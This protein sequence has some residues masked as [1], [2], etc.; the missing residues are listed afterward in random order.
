MDRR[1]TYHGITVD[2]TLFQIPEMVIRIDTQI[3]VHTK[4]DTDED[5]IQPN[6]LHFNS[7]EY[8]DW[9]WTFWRNIY[10]HF[11]GPQQTWSMSD[12]VECILMLEHVIIVCVANAVCRLTLSWWYTTPF[13][14]ANLYRFWSINFFNQLLAISVPGRQS[15][16]PKFYFGLCCRT[17][18]TYFFC[19]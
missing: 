8:Q 1:K 12:F 18:K 13:L 15:G 16:A 6:L 4:R 7:I 17:Y 5:A 14:L 10:H 11:I 9:L 3:E 2:W 19:K